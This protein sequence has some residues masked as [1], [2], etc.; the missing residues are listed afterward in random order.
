MCEGNTLKSSKKVGSI[1]TFAAENF[2][3]KM[4][5]VCMEY[6]FTNNNLAIQNL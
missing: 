2:P 5:F 6:Q 1:A 4:V 3:T